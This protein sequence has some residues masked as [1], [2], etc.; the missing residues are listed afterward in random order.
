MRAARLAGISGRDCEF[1]SADPVSETIERLLRGEIMAI[2]GIGGFHLSVDATSEDA[3]M[4]LRERKHRYGK[5]L[6]VMVRD[7][8]AARLLCELTLAEETLLETPARPIVLA[9]ATRAATALLPQSRR[10]FRGLV[11]S[12]PTRRCNICSLPI[13][14]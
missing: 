9:R 7:L 8:A 1:E 10:E 11:S 5:P 6:A 14:A 13:R 3:V 12:C 2:K 4:R